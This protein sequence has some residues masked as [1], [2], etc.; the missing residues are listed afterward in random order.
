DNIMVD[1]H[2]TNMRIRELAAIIIPD[3]RTIQINPWDRSSVQPIMKAILSANI[4]L[5]PVSQGPLIR[6][7][8]PE[9]SGERRQE[10]AKIA[11]NMAEEARVG[12]RSVRRDSM[13]LLKKAKKEGIVT[14]DELKK[15][16]KEI[17]K[18][19]D[20]VIDRIA[21]LLEAKEKD[22]TKV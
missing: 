6:C 21:V 8:V 11:K 5:T 12:V 10:L 13:E 17:Q 2:G 4:G 18:L 14:E 1:L 20:E 15:F 9:M 22:L 16:E 7:I 19:T 3:H